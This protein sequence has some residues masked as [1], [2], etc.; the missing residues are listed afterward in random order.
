[1]D[2]GVRGLQRN[3]TRS[4]SNEGQFPPTN[5]DSISTTTAP[6]ITGIS[7]SQEQDND[8]SVKNTGLPI[9]KLSS[10]TTVWG[11][12]DEAALEKKHKQWQQLRATQMAQLNEQIGMKD[13]VKGLIIIFLFRTAAR[14]LFGLSGRVAAA[15]VVVFTL[16][17][18]LWKNRAPSRLLK[19]QP[20]SDFTVWP[21][22]GQIGFVPAA[23]TKSTLF[24]QIDS[25]KKRGFKSN[26]LVLF[27]GVRDF[28]LMV[29]EDREY[30]LKTNWKNFT[31]NFPG[32]VGFQEMFAEVMG[33]G[34]FAVDGDEWQDHRKVASH[35][36]SANGLK[37]KMEICFT[38]HGK[39]LV[40]LLHE[41]AKTK[42]V[43]DFQEVAQALTFDTI[44]D[45]AF[46]TFPDALGEY[47]TRGK[48]VDF[49]IRFDRV[50]Q[51]STLR[52]ILPEPIWKTMRWLNIGAERQ[53]REDGVELRAYVQKVV[54]KKR[55]ALAASNNNNNNDVESNKGDDLLAMYIKTAKASGKSYMNDD[56]YLS[57]AVL[58]FMIAGRD[59]TSCTLINLFRFLDEKPEVAEK[60]REEFIKVVGKDRHVGWD[61]VRELR[62]GSAVFNETLR[63]RPPVFGDMRIVN[64]DVT[65]PSGLFLPAG[66]RASI[67]NSAIGRD[68][69]LWKNPDEFL[70]ERWI[71]PEKPDKV[72]GRVDEYIHPVFW[73]GPRLCLGKDMAR[74]E[75]LNIAWT[76]LKEFNI[77]V[78]P[79]QDDIT[80]NGPVQF[81]KFG[82][83][84][85]CEGV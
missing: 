26:E 67:V 43:F 68:P 24:T 65:L 60:M 73:G 3:R 82:V 32:V 55:A 57:D 71:D 49:L 74:L 1:M 2:I 77:K 45:I 11:S 40:K 8:D 34:I 7:S 69:N 79:G 56:D 19:E 35:L 78:L 29:P 52:F 28:A 23:L 27:G 33:R 21:I 18:T 81:F 80:I 5:R 17:R 53:I 13:I 54:D 50:Q 15:Y 31:K 20:T 30:M 6:T 58:N 39:A 70:P 16:I 51:T 12:E 22:F 62:Y 4:N 66:S 41:K 36:F 9:K 61:D 76:I 46:G 64:S 42:E 84:V 85:V 44:S 47:M 75:T 37:T 38:E 14:K 25:A 72:V 63:L 10:S 59:T 83:K 48:K